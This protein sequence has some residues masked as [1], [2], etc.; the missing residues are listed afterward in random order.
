M[1]R[2]GQN[3]ILEVV[4]THNNVSKV[5]TPKEIIEYLYQNNPKCIKVL[6]NNGVNE[7]QFA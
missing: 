4:D 6:N 1:G 3:Y 5:Y 2:F 7:V